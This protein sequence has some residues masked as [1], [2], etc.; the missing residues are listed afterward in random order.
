[1]GVNSEKHDDVNGDA[2]EEFVAF[3]VD[4]ETQTLIGDF[5]R[6]EYGESLFIPDAGKSV[7]DLG[8]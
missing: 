7:D 6:E 3:M 2:A 5:R 4:P 1:M 8:N